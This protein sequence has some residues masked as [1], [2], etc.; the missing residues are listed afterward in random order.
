[1]SR[2][3]LRNSTRGAPAQLPDAWLVAIAIAALADERKTK[4]ITEGRARRT[5]ASPR[6]AIV[7]ALDASQSL[8]VAKRRLWGRRGMEGGRGSSF[9]LV[10]QAFGWPGL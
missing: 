6:K 3:V 9:A 2:F 5:I 4:A 7:G 1:M 10:L 8:L